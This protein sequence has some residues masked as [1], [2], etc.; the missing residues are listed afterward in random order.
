MII[1]C[2]DT[3][4]IA[5]IISP[6]E[7]EDLKNYLKNAVMNFCAEFYDQIYYDRWFSLDTIFC[8]NGFYKQKP[9]NAV[10][11]YYLNIGKTEK[12]A[13]VFALLDLNCLLEEILAE[14]SKVFTKKAPDKTSYLPSYML[15]SETLI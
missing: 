5:A 11:D 4:K 8:D 2:K 13:T 15:I 14:D 3:S 6:K 12:D 1:N 10:Y 9:L 7:T